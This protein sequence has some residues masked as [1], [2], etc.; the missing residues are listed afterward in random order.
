MSWLA[1]DMGRLSNGAPTSCSAMW[2]AI[3]LEPGAK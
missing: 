2:T 1:K 3:E